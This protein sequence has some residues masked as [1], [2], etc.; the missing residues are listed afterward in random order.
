MG[1]ISQGYIKAYIFREVY[2][3]AKVL[4]STVLERTKV[5]EGE[6]LWVADSVC[7]GLRVRISNSSRGRSAVFYY[8]YKDRVTGKQKPVKLGAYPGMGIAEARALIDNKLRGM[9]DAGLDVTAERK[10]EVR[11][12]PSVQDG[13]VSSLIPKYLELCEVS[14]KSEGTIKQYRR[15]LRP[16]SRWWGERKPSEINRGDVQDL[17]HRV[18]KE[19]V[20]SID[21]D[22]K[23]LPV[24]PAAARERQDWHWQLHGVF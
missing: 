13:T 1:V 20:P 15:Y 2:T 14:G 9:A 19:G 21:L 3:V 17:F 11:V 18:R 12:L 7:K 8:R 4:T 6:L 22:G 24:S 23:K 10:R 5:N 16:A